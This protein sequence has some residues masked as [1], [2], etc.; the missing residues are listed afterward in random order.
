MLTQA[1]LL[2]Q[3][4]H[5]IGSKNYYIYSA[6]TSQGQSLF[7]AELLTP[8]TIGPSTRI[9]IPTLPWE[10]VKWGVNE[11]P[12]GLTSP[13]GQVFM[14]FSG[15]S[16]ET[17]S[18]ALGYL[19]LTPGANPLLASSWIKNPNAQF[20]AANGVYGPGHHGFFKSPSGQDYIVYHGNAAE[21][22]G[23]GGSRSTR[24][25]RISWNSNGTPNLGTPLNVNT[26]I[27][28]PV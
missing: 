18:Y 16:C 20:S 8:A 19:A 26:D 1:L 9:S 21:N 2:R 22:G 11:G 6:W 3:T 14:F 7:I 4:V 24:V 17:A 28:E 15:S 13:S 12:Y 25:Q 10:T 27:A 5:P 23:C